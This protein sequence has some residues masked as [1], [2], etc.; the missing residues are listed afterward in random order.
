MK[1]A[2]WIQPTLIVMALMYGVWQH[3][4]ASGMTPSPEKAPAVAAP[5]PSTKIAD[6]VQLKPEQTR[7]IITHKV[8]PEDLAVHLSTLGK[9]SFNEEKTSL[10]LAPIA[11][12]VSGLRVRVGDR[13]SRGDVLFM[14]HSRDVA[15]AKSDYLES[16]RDVELAHQTFEITKK[17]Y[18]HQAAPMIQFQQDQN[19]LA[20]AETRAARTAEQLRVLGIDAGAV[21]ETSAADARIAIKAAIDAT[22]VERHLTEGQFVQGDSTPLVTLAD[23]SS[24]WVLADVFERDLANVKVG[25]AADVTTLAYPN[26][27]FAAEVSHISDVVD[28]N[29]RTVKV[30]LSVA[31]RDGRLKPEM[32]ASVDLLIDASRQ[33]LA[34][35]TKSVLT[36]DGHQMVY[37]KVGENSYK[38][39]TVVVSTL[40][41]SRVRVIDGL[42]AGDEVVT[43]GALLLR[44][45]QQK[46]GGD[47]S[48]EG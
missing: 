37:V 19:N 29:S 8:S 30:R 25:Q 26:S 7:S 3:V 38:N 45:E 17:L 35:P 28:P 1:L 12:Q 36:D 34:I 21:T 48:S 32:F 22:V 46:P 43:D 6:G 13:V 20:K 44:Y 4:T 9:I 11:G 42:K 18:E 10:V 23:L 5:V 16:R 39:R 40:D 27:H 2:K 15:A 41:E 47:E 24:V 31:N 14:L 33:G